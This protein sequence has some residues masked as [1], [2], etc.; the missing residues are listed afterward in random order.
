MAPTP[1][2]DPTVA[3]TPATT[4]ASGAA[5]PGGASSGGGS[6]A[7]STVDGTVVQPATNEGGL[8]DVLNAVVDQ[9]AATLKPG[10][11]AV[12]ASTFTFPIL[13]ALLVL[14]FLLVQHRLDERDPKLRHAPSSAFETY[15][16]FEE[17]DR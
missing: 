1:T 7:T 15:I 13:L 2:P 10:V 8:A 3:P 16:A 12:V 4:Q 11:V 14:L 6:T 5:T 9:V 17:E